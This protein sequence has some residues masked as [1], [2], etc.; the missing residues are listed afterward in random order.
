[1]EDPD[2]GR[3]TPVVRD[4]PL[5]W[6]QEFLW[7]GYNSPPPADR[8]ALNLPVLVRVPTRTDVAAAEAV[9]A[10]LVARHESLRTTYTLDTD[11]RPRQLVRAPYRPAVRL[12]PVGGTA[13]I[14]RA[15]LDFQRVAIDVEREWP[16][17]AYLLAGRDVRML[18]LVCSHLATDG[19]GLTVLAEAIS[20]GVAGTL[21]PDEETPVSQPLDQVAFQESAAGQR[22]LRAGLAYGEEVYSRSAAWTFA[23]LAQGRSLSAGGHV[24]A[25]LHSERLPTATSGLADRLG[26]TRSVV[27]LAAF[28]ALLRDLSGGYGLTLHSDFSNR[29]DPATRRSAAC[30]FQPALLWLPLPAGTTAREAVL[31]VRRAMLAGFRRA[32]CSFMDS[33]DMIARTQV[34]RGLLIRICVNFDFNE[35]QQTQSTA[36]GD[37][38]AARAVTVKPLDIGHSNLDVRLDV[39]PGSGVDELVLVAHGVLVPPEQARCLVTGIEA[40]LLMLAGDRTAIDRDLTD[41]VEAAGIS[42][43]EY[44]PQWSWVDGCLV[45]RDQVAAVLE[46]HPAVERC[47][48][49]VE[50]A[51]GRDVLAAYLECRRG[52]PSLAGLRRH[53]LDRLDTEAAVIVPHRFVVCRQLPA[54]PG[55]VDAWR[56]VPVLASGDGVGPMHDTPRTPAEVALWR[57][58]TRYADD[59]VPD[60]SSSYVSV[61]GRAATATAVVRALADRG[62][63]GIGPHDLL[64]PVSLTH[65]ATHLTRRRR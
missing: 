61:G 14:Y 47:V 17:R 52:T 37:R 35:S 2:G 33:R 6:S 36:P 57:A 5:T 64:R 20:R 27:Y 21:D 56:D 12:V 40:I 23:G 54:E 62:Y 18:L 9:L 16:V 3:L 41:L 31:V 65:L 45:N 53:V 30:L 58:I 51:D 8:S 43:P 49:T 28:A 22:V 59:L 34:R 55:G 24:R 4:G 25:T 42:R 10:A 1:M 13:E 32:R 63:G 15:S 60:M 44:G 48:V 11:G 38:P 19:T 39:R 26:V 46:T 7:F 29:L 50:Q